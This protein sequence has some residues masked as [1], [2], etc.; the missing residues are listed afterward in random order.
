MAISPV[1]SPG[2]SCG[3]DATPTLSRRANGLRPYPEAVTTLQADRHTYSDYAALIDDYHARGWTDGLPIVPPT[4]DAVEQF[5]AAAGL[6][7]DHVVGA[8]PTREVTVTAEHVAINAVMAGCRF[9]YMPTVVA[10]CRAHLREKGN[11]HS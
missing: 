1:P 3:R 8:V 5:L 11:C 2:R 6:E 10:A 7:P 4:P 9:D